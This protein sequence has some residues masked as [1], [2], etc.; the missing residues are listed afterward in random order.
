[1]NYPL[2]YHCLVPGDYSNTVMTLTF[3]PAMSSLIAAV[4]T[5]EDSFL[6]YPEIFFGNLR[7]PA[8]STAN[9]MLVPD[10]ANATITDNDAAVIGFSGN[11]SIVE[12]GSVNIAVEVLSGVLEREVII[13]VDTADGTAQ[14]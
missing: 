2:F 11:Y 3:T 8:G 1:M 6:E 13:R 4:N 14:G 5:L 7:L 9:V 10:M 12:G